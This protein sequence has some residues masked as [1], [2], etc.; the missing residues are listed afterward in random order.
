MPGVHSGQFIRDEFIPDHGLAMS[1]RVSLAVNQITL[2]ESEA[3]KFLR[4][5][6]LSPQ[7][8]KPGW[9]LVR[10]DSHNL[11]WLKVMP[12]RMNNYYPKEWKI[13]MK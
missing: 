8:T 1:K 7:E 10:F 3:L 9:T 12:N 11:G 2:G 13:R 5:E 4:L 6:N